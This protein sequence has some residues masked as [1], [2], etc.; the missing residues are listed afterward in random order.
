MRT[1]GERSRWV[2]YLRVSTTDQAD[3]ELSLTAQRRAVSEF[4][5]RQGVAIAEEYLE[6]GASGTDPNRRVLN[7]LLGD[8]LQPGSTIRTIVVHH[9]SRFTRDATHARIVKS[10]LRR[11]GVRVLSVSQELSDDPMGKLMEGLFECIDQYESELN[12]LRTSAAMREAVRQGFFPGS[13]I[14]YGYRTV[15]VEARPGV[16][17]H[18]LEVEPREAEVVRLLYR[19]YVAEAGAKAVARRLNQLG[20]RTRAGGLWDKG[21]VLLVLDQPAVSGTL[22]WGRKSGTRTRPRDEW[23]TLATEPIVDPETYALAQALRAQREPSRALG[24]AAAKP[25]VLTGLLWC[26]R[27]GASYQLETSGKKVDGATYRYCY[28][29]CRAACRTGIEACAG[30]RVATDTLDGAVLR[31]IA[32]VVCTETR[33]AP[34]AKRYG[35]PVERLREAWRTIVLCD[36]EVGRSYALHLIRQ[37]EVHE[38]QIVVTPK[39][40]GRTI[41]PPPALN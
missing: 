40:G 20:Y 18:R 28:Y 6:P 14:P 21:M 29:N 37:I 39:P 9:T 8:A 25:H 27:C 11:A 41:T 32:D 10:K 23:L 13:R 4:A 31:A 17:R 7:R 36:H 38:E 35:W 15:A 22:Y 3:R 19:L 30:F 2:S 1:S 5:A 16:I 33:A 26:G 12:G 34:L 24:R